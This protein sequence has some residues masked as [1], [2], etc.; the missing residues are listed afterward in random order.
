MALAVLEDNDSFEVWP[1]NLPA[2]RAFTA[3]ASQWRVLPLG[4]AGSAFIGL[5]YGACKVAL[6]AHGLALAPADFAAFQV[7]EAE[8][9]RA[10]NE[11][12]AA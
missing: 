10:L 3:C 7:I 11:R 8:A 6:D 1:E 12:R 9:A 5:D 2:V 4:L